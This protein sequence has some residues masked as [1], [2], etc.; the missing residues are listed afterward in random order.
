MSR[1]I[2]WVPFDATTPPQVHR[3]PHQMTKFKR[4]PWLYCRKCGLIALKN[5]ASH[6]A[7]RKDCVTVA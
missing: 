6:Q 7:V 4:L 1:Q 2:E 3:G 5:A